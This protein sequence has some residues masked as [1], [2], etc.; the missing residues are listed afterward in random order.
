MT[1]TFKMAGFTASHAISSIVGGEIL[2]PLFGAIT[3]DNDSTLS[4]IALGESEKAIN[5]GMD[6]LERN[7]DGNNGAVF[8]YDG[9]ANL[10]NEKV[11]SLII[12][13]K[14]YGNSNVHF[15]IA[16]PYRNASN[17]KGFAITHP[18]LLNVT[19]TD[20]SQIPALMDAFYDGL[21]S[22]EQGVK[23]WAECFSE[24]L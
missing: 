20:E 13:I 11:E 5:L 23:V 2:I 17:Q 4:R 12:N 8:I 21:E 3:K 15:L 18:K 19:G 1:Q 14:D 7:E 24:E 10:N 22:H 6:R 16:F 9:Y